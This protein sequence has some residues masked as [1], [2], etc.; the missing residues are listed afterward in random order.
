MLVHFAH[1]LAFPFAIFRM[2]A[3]ISALICGG[4]E[5]QV[6]AI[7]RFAETF[8]IAFQIQDDLL[9]ID[10]NA[11]AASKGIAS[12]SYFFSIAP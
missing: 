6:E 5:E 9:N 2:S 12:R 10:T 7:A 11:L 4:T 8:G 1:V 3:K